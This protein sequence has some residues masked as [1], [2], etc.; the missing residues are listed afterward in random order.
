MLR[1]YRTA[2]PGLEEQPPERRG[3]RP[4]QRVGSSVAAYS[5]SF[6]IVLVS[7]EASVVSPAPA[8]EP[9]GDLAAPRP[10]CLCWRS[11]RIT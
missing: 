9:L 10:L 8:A 2:G 3:I 4:L 6:G 11:L 7:P 1:R 5:S